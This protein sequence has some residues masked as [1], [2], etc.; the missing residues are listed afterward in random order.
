M[1]IS[2]QVDK[3]RAEV[4]DLIKQ[5]EAIRDA[6]KELLQAAA[7]GEQPVSGQLVLT[8]V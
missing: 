7:R 3:F 5:E 2:L 1:C 6:R 4:N 8:V